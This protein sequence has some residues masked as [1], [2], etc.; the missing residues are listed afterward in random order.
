MDPVYCNLQKEKSPTGSWIL[1]FAA[2]LIGIL[3][4]LWLLHGAWCVLLCALTLTLAALKPAHGHGNGNGRE[5]CKM[6]F[7]AN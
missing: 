6:N 4:R 3:W 5:A 1:Q 7:S 2:S